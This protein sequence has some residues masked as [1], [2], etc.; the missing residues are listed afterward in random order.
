MT[1]EIENPPHL[2]VFI[3][4]T[5]SVISAMAMTEVR[6]G[7]HSIKDTNKVFGAV[8]GIIGLAGPMVHATMAISFEEASIFEIFTNMLGD[9]VTEISNDILDAVGEFTNMICGDSKRRLAERGIVLD[10]ATPLVISGHDVRIR[11]RVTRRTYIL[12]F[13]T[14]KG[15]FVLETNLPGQLGK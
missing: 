9:T 1:S 10:M 8:T 7:A 5:K 4:A 12:P 6:P 14:S 15:C 11:D 3:E 2:D 13:Y